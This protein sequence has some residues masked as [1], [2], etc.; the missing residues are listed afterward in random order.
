MS[1]EPGFRRGKLRAMGI[2]LQQAELMSPEQARAFLEGSE[3]VS[4]QAGSQALKY[5]LFKAVLRRFL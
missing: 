2:V 1:R 5:E 3:S 4:S